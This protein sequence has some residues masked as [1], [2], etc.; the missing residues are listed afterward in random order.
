MTYCSCRFWG[1]GTVFVGNYWHFWTGRRLEPA[2]QIHLLPR[3]QGHSGLIS[4]LF[5]LI[6]LLIQGR[7]GSWGLISWRGV[8]YA[9]RFFSE[10]KT[11]KSATSGRKAYIVANYVFPLVRISGGNIPRPTGH[12]FEALSCITC[13]P[14]AWVLRTCYTES[15]CDSALVKLFFCLTRSIRGLVFPSKG[16]VTHLVRR[17][18]C[19]NCSAAFS[20]ELL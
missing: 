7:A 6:S 16:V 18:F 19:G 2:T 10:K 12:R 5:S 1:T 3:H 8:Q 20:S 17:R 9:T 11:C 4:F 14:F 15:A 13:R